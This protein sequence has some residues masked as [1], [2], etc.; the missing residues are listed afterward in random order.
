MNFLEEIL[1]VVGAI[2]FPYGI[3]EIS[4]GGGDVKVRLVL[5][6]ISVGLFTAE[7]ILSFR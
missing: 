7:A 3:Y 2:M 4:K 6:M 1:F 5:I